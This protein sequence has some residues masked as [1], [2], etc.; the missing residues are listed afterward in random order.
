MSEQ[1]VPSR[2]WYLFLVAGILAVSAGVIS[3]V[4]PKITLG[5]IALILGLYLI[6]SGLI[7]LVAGIAEDDADGSLRVLA[8]LL[9]IVSLIA[10]VIILRNPGDSLKTIALIVGIFLIIG[11]VIE[12]FR[13]F[14]RPDH[15]GIGIVAGLIELAAGVIIAAQ[16]KIGLHT[17]AVVIGIV[18][19]LRGIAACVLA[20]QVKKFEDEAAAA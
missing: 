7:E 17:L 19:I 15:R 9:G 4:Y 6:I 16:P 12:V 18:L 2:F 13:A 11:G 5:V 14:S 10:G 3:I 8:A 20:F 1:P